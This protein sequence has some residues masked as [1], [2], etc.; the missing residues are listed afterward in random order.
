MLSCVPVTTPT[1]PARHHKGKVDA[2]IYVV[3]LQCFDTFLLHYKG[4][5]Y[6]A[7]MP[8]ILG[9]LSRRQKDL[10]CT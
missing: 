8:T 5:V 10:M 7:R 2:V 6:F 1:F 9:G 3:Q 4:S